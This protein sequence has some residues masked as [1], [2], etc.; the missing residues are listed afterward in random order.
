[1]SMLIDPFDSRDEIFLGHPLPNAHNGQD[2]SASSTLGLVI[3]SL[4]FGGLH[5][6]VSPRG[7]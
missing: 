7:I 5:L 1:M 4:V 6:T 3:A 2:G